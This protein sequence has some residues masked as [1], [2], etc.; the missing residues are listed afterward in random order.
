VPAL[1]PNPP[2]PPPP[3]PGPNWPVFD[4]APALEL[5][6]LQLGSGVHVCPSEREGYG[7]Y[8][9]EARAAG[10]LVIAPDHPP[11]NEL[12]WAWGGG[13]GGCCGRLARACNV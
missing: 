1:T 12:V 3:R 8:I 5:A 6:R 9:S 10:A 13:L 2:P 4:P 7:L 11:M